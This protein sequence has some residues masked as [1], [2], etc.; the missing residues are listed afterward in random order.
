ANQGVYIK[1]QMITRIEDKNGTVL[2]QP[3]PE[4]KDVINEETA[5]AVIKLLEGVTQGGSGVRLRTTGS[6]GPSYKRVTGHP[7]AFTNPIAGKTG[8][9]QNHSD[10]WFMGMVPNLVTGVW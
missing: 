3:V 1:P 8:T 5:F 9:S 2:Y 10:G 4:T 7:Y 6:G